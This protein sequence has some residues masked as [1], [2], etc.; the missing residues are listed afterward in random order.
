MDRRTLR[1]RTGLN[2]NSAEN[3]IQAL[4]LLALLCCQAVDQAVTR[5]ES[6]ARRLAS[7]QLVRLTPPVVAA[8]NQG[9]SA[10]GLGLGQLFLLS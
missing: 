1:R 7:V 8:Y 6:G 10:A 5:G 2:W 9:L 4:R 3:R